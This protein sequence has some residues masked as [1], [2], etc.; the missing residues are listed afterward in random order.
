[1]R[2]YDDLPKKL[3]GSLQMTEEQYWDTYH[4]TM[5]DGKLNTIAQLLRDYLRRVKNEKDRESD[6]ENDGKG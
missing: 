4:I 1:M 2:S 6:V 5:P 3:D